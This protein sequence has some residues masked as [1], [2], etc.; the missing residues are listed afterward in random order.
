MSIFKEIA[1]DLYQWSEF[2]KEKQLS[3]NGHYL[4]HNGEAVI[5]DP[6]N[7]LDDQLQ[8]LKGLIEKHPNS[9]LKAILLTN[10]HHE[11][12]SSKIK[13]FFS[14]PVYIH[15]SDASELAFEADHTF[16]NYNKL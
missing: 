1:P 11:R 13:E 15:E 4:V 7:L 3:F 8:S 6:P 16:L 12:M 14:I 2:S 10:V 9:P 5:I